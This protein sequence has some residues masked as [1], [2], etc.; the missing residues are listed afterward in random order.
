MGQNVNVQRE[1][2]K[3]LKETKVMFPSIETREKPWP[4]SEN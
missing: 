4:N 3:D 1:I 2:I